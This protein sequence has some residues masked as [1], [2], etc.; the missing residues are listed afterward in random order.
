M[1]ESPSWAANRCSTGQF[2]V[3]YRKRRVHYRVPRSP[4]WILSSSTL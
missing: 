1:E 2:Q 4:P 3:F